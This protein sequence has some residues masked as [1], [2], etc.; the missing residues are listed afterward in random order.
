MTVKRYCRQLYDSLLPIVVQL[1][2]LVDEREVSQRSKAKL[3]MI[4]TELAIIA[5]WIER[6][7]A[8]AQSDYND[9]FNE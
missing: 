3:E 6:E 9:G 2:W 5:R 7:P 1:R 8:P 4:K